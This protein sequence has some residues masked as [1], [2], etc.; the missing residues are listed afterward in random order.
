LIG[1][2]KEK[3]PGANR[4]LSERRAGLAQLGSKNPAGSTPALLTPQAANAAQQNPVVAKEMVL[5]EG[6]QPLHVRH[7]SWI[8]DSGI[9]RSWAIRSNRQW[10]R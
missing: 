7:A 4:G 3:A 6:T 1:C 10:T 2:H 9:A 5:D 8:S